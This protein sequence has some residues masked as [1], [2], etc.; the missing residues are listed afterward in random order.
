MAARMADVAAV[1]SWLLE[2]YG[3]VEISSVEVLNHIDHDLFS[4][5]EVYVRVLDVTV[6]VWSQDEAARIARRLGLPLIESHVSVSCG[7]RYGWCSWAGYVDVETPSGLP[8]NLAMR[9][10]RL[11]GE[12]E[13]FETMAAPAP[14]P[15]AVA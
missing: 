4:A 10:A 7:A 2:Q 14:E 11:L 15:R 8:M 5:R 3:A 13:R 6:C 1:S 9:A 12:S